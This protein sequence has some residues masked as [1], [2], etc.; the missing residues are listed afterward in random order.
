MSNLPPVLSVAAWKKNTSFL[1]RIKGVADDKEI[2]KLLAELA[3]LEQQVSLKQPA[4]EDFDAKTKEFKR[5]LNNIQAR[6]LQ[7]APKWQQHKA[8]PKASREHVELVGKAAKLAVANINAAQKVYT[9]QL[10]AVRN[11]QDAVSRKIRGG[12]FPTAEIKNIAEVLAKFAKTTPSFRPQA[13]AWAKM[14]ALTPKNS[15]GLP[16]MLEKVRAANNELHDFF[17]AAGDR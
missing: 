2:P 3:R 4:F 8:V 15:A 17:D 6:A 9:K 10:E 1:T 11:D 16:A 5:T 12:E 7:V 13:Q 14:R